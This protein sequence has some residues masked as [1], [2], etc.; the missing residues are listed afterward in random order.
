MAIFDGVRAIMACV[1]RVAVWCAPTGAQYRIAHGEQHATI[2]EVGAAVREYRVGDREVFAPFAEG[3]IPN[4]FQGAVLLPW[5]NRIADGRYEFDGEC[6]QLPITEPERQ[7]AL[8]GLAAWQ[9]W[10]LVEQADDHVTLELRLLPTP[11]YPFYLDTNVEYSIG[12]DG[13]RVQARSTNSGD[14]ACPYAIGFHP[15]LAAA[16]GTTLDACTLTLD[17]RRHFVCDERLLPLH[18]EPVDNTPYDFRALRGLAGT[19]LDDAFGGVVADVEGRSW[20][21]LHGTDGRT[22]ALW[23]DAAFGYWQLYSGDRLSPDLARR[24]LAAEPMTAPPDAFRSGTGL[25]RLE[26]GGSITSTWGAVLL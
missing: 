9:R 11:G 15:Y 17:V 10:A 2:V 19:L 22:A 6:Y 14:R 3:E 8:H 21:K 1:E 18:D 23:A 25:I 20:V 4:A 13:L 26:P 16:A 7:T 12:P 24:S 5:P